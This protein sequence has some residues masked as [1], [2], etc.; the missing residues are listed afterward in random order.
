MYPPIEEFLV[1]RD[2]SAWFRLRESDDSGSVYRILDPSGEP[3][4][5][6][7]FPRDVSIEAADLNSAWGVFADELDVQ[8]VVRYTISDGGGE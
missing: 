4:G 7:R 2:G 8:S 5:Q 6:V 1:G 3:Y